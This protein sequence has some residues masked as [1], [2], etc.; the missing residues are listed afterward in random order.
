M[1][2]DTEIDGLLLGAM[3]ADPEFDV[4][5]DLERRAVTLT[6]LDADVDPE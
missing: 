1:D 4:D 6:D 3:V 2:T 5:G